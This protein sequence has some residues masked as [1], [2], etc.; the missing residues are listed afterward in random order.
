MKEK[1]R[2]QTKYR[3]AEH[4]SWR[5]VESEAV[6]LNL[7][8]GVYHSLN[9]TGALIWEKLGAGATVDDVKAAVCREYEVEAD[10]IQKHMET[11]VQKLLKA[12]LL[13]PGREENH[14]R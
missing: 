11:L 6:V 10:D 1:P 7:D 14:G 2:N 5:R 9:E 13:R 8:T 12:N 3:H 4:V